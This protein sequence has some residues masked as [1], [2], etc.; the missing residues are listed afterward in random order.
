MVSI[1]GM[2]KSGGIPKIISTVVLAEKVFEGSG[3]ASLLNPTQAVSNI[4]SRV[5]GTATPG[6]P[7]PTVG[8]TIIGSSGWQFQLKP[9][10]VTGAGMLIADYILGKIHFSFPGK[11]LIRRY[12]LKPVGAGLLGAGAINIILG[13]PQFAGGG[14]FSGNVGSLTTRSVITPRFSGFTPPQMAR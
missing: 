14:A 10:I 7:A 5:T 11:S 13:D 4:I 6:L 3:K 1:S 8:Q 12:A 2:A 9:E